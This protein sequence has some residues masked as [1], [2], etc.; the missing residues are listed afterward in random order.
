MSSPV[1]VPSVPVPKPPAVVVAAVPVP[2]PSAVVVPTVPVPKPPAVV[3]A[4]A[5]VPTPPVVT[6]PTPWVPPTLPVPKAPVTVPT[7]PVATQP[8]VVVPT[9]PL[10]RPPVVTVSTVSA[11]KGATEAVLTLSVLTVPTLTVPTVPLPKP[12]VVTVLTVPLP[13]PPVVT[14]PTVPVPKPPV[15]TVPTVP[16][17]KP[18][19]VTVPTLPV[20][21][22][23]VVTVPTLPVPKPPVVKVPVLPAPKPAVGNVTTAPTP[24]K[25]PSVKVTSPTL[26][27]ISQAPAQAT[28]TASGLSPSLSSH[29]GSATTGGTSTATVHPAGG[30]AGAALLFLG[31]GYS[32]PLVA[33]EEETARALGGLSRHDQARTAALVL[34]STVRRLEGC[35][36]YLPQNLRRVLELIAGVNAPTALSPEAVAGQLHVTM[37]RVSRLERLAL[38]RL[39]LAARTYSCGIAAPGS[40][41]PLAFSGLAVL[42]GE[43]GGP[44]GGVKAARYATTAAPGLEASTPSPGGPSLLGIAHPSLERVALLLILAGVLLIG[45]LFADDLWPRAIHHDWRSR[46]IHRHPWNWRR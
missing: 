44:A 33:M 15:V 28:S 3:V 6:V 12:P 4:T 31:G 19:V 7:P 42:P 35:L 25:G 11:P 40:T 2:K 8:A 34:A 13:K 17:P 23:P 46:R 16:V 39:L 26:G 5:P 41:G 37:R 38:R 24:P 36:S 27:G 14:V 43:E 9:M 10:P 20:P 22:P 18:P 45:L 30:Q 21:K 29:Q 1:A 32:G